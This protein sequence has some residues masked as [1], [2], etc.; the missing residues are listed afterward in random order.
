[1]NFKRI[2][3]IFLCVMLFLGIGITAFAE[4][5]SMPVSVN[6][7]AAILI[8]CSSGKVLMAMNEHERLNPASVTKIMTILLTLEAIDQEKIQFTDE[9]KTS[10]FASKKGGSQIWLKEGEVMT[11][12]ELLKAT[13]IG[14][15]N[16]AACA[17]AEY[18]AGSEEAFVDMMNNRAKELGMNDTHFENCTGLDDETTDHL[19]SAY[20]I[21]I[22]SREV[23]KH[24]IIKNYSTVWMDSLRNG[25]TELVNTNKLVRFYSGTTGLKTGT[26]SKAGN[27]LSA[28]AERDGTKLCAVILGAPDSKG[29]FENAKAM[30]NY[31]FS[32]YKT[33]K[34]KIC[35]ELV[36]NVNV[37]HGVKNTI[38]PIIPESKEIMIEKGTEDKISQTVEMCV[39]VE[40]PVEKGQI[41]GKVIFTLD[42]QTIDEYNLTAGENIAKI[43]FYYALKFLLASLIA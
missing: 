13:V 32:S 9:V 23:M 40:A 25:A 24:D 30:L 18:I 37:I 27:C 29:R 20:D 1:M 12:D 16:D 22:M 7:K 28:T 14:S 19:T 43:N 42:G 2:I 36:T 35:T 17:L 6:A 33:V 41:L 26:T 15:A 21:A 8:D 3:S 10:A 5:N 39:D 31:G 34:P 11:V 38:T 4:E